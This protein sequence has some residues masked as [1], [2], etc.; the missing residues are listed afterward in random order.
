MKVRRVISFIAFSLCLSYAPEMN[1]LL[2]ALVALVQSDADLVLKNGVAYRA[3]AVAIRDGKIVATRDVDKF[4][5]PHTKVIDLKG[6]FVCPGFN[7]T[8]IH[9]AGGGASLLRLNLVGMS[10]AE[11]QAAVAEA[12]QK[13]KP[14]EWVYGRGWD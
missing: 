14:G 3:E 9:F 8:H 6:C 12:V 13:A 4:V 11:I 1:P 7:D 10:L 5:G 2:F